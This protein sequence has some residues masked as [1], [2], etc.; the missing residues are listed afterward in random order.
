[1]N[2]NLG[3]SDMYIY[4]SWPFV[5]VKCLSVKVFVFHSIHS[6]IKATKGWTD[7]ILQEAPS[8]PTRPSQCQNPI[9]PWCPVWY[10]TSP[11]SLWLPLGQSVTAFSIFL[12]RGSLMLPWRGSSFTTVTESFLIKVLHVYSLHGLHE[13]QEFVFICSSGSKILK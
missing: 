9:H 10:S 2:S 3:N 4:T 12:G 8:Q 13:K 7:L 1:M 5:Y 6:F 11:A